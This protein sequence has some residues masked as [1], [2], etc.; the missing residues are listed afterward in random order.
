MSHATKTLQ[1]YQEVLECVAQGRLPAT[2][3]QEY[4]PRFIQSQGTRYT[5]RLTELGS[6]FMGAL[7]QINRDSRQG[8][9]SEDAEGGIPLPIFE[10][11]NASQW[12]EQYA[13]Y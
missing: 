10:T 13:E 4:F 11:A 6:E 3:F 9:E 8:E 1:M 5:E 2:V 7:V 12:F